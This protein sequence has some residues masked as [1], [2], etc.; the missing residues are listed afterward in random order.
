L[1]VRVSRS[2]DP[3]IRGV[4]GTVVDESRNMLILAGKRKK[5]RIPKDVATF[6]FKLQ[7]G[8]L[9]DVDGVRIAGPGKHLHALEVRRTQDGLLREEA[10]P[11]GVAPEQDHE[12]LIEQALLE[13]GTEFGSD[14]LDLLHIPEHHGDALQRGDGRLDRC[15]DVAKETAEALPQ[16]FEK[17][18]HPRIHLKDSDHEVE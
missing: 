6:R 12:A 5:L 1:N 11:A 15:A 10:N 18:A 17:R 3:T 14:V 13:S 7:N 4:R 2:K 16:S 8:T 9:V